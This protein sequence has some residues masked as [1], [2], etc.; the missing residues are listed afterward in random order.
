MNALGDVFSLEGESLT[1][2]PAVPGPRA[3][4]PA[5]NENTTLA[6][7]ATNAP[8]NRAELGRLIVRGHDAFAAC[9]RPAHTG[10]DGD[11]CFAVSVGSTDARSHDATAAQPDLHNL[12]EAAFEAVGRAIANA[13]LAGS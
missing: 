10:S 1:G 3:A 5:P 2:G 4:S 13:V 6:V 8:L 7:L 9:L 11:I 12:A